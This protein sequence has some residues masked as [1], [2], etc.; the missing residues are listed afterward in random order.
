VALPTNP[1]TPWPP[2]A[3]VPVLQEVRDLGAWYS[4]DWARIRSVSIPSTLGHVFEGARTAREQSASN[5][6]RS[7]LVVPMAG[8][9]ARTSADLLF[10]ETPVF[11]CESKGAQ[12]RLNTVL[13]LMGF[14]SMLLE[15]AE[16]CAAK[17][18]IYWRVTWD[19]SLVTDRPIVSFLQ[20][21]NAV[22][23]WRMGVLTAVTF[24]SVLAPTVEDGDK[25]VW[26]HL[27]RHS[28]SRRGAVIEHGLYLGTDSQLGQPMPLTD[29]PD[30]EGIAEALTDPDDG[31]DGQA[32]VLDGVPLTAGYVPNVRPN[33][34]NPGSMIG[35]A[36]IDGLFTELA[37]INEAWTSWMRDL[38]LAKARLVVPSSYLEA[39][40]A[41]RGAVF[42]IDRELY[43]ATNMMPP[44]DG[45][46]GM[47]LVQFGIRTDEH[48]RTIKALAQQ[49]ITSAGYSLRSFGMADAGNAATATEVRSHERLSL[50]T[51]ERKTRYF[52]VGLRDLLFCLQAVDSFMGNPDAVEPSPVTVEFKDSVSE[53]PKA[54]AET[55]N[56]LFQAQAATIETRVRLVHPDWDDERVAKEVEGIL[57]ETGTGG[58]EDPDPGE[59]DPAA[60]QDL[61]DEIPDGPPRGP[62][63]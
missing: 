52:D 26:R 32:I 60:E 62:T 23:E 29:H 28:V 37:G 3:M 20:Q 40:G 59:L 9:V 39:Q 61:A 50:I 19:R 45:G 35:R 34:R 6:T 5:S 41:G 16:L 4:N 46:P 49:V 56:L 44:K 18:G 43:E 54:Q 21:D 31:G 47:T 11:T 55:A 27:E 10:S 14:E 24:W 33:R 2:P 25:T 63:G 57:S 53:D 8:D 22:P 1:K 36:D 58:V 15:A 12:D 7:Q 13:D 38:R 30:T 51:R 48:E 42:D 17:T